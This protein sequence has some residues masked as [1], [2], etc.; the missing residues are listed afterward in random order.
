MIE[1]DAVLPV[2]PLVEV[3]LPVVLF[4]V[5]AAVPV[6]VIFET[7]VPPPAM[8]APDRVITFEATERVPPH[9]EVEEFAAVS[10]AGNES[11]K[12][13]P[14]SVVAEFGLVTVIV[15]VEV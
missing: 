9:G 10:P 8:L 1:A 13:T 7:H 4:S 11:V 12:A 3:T 5:P 6:T 15:S 14:V 2:P